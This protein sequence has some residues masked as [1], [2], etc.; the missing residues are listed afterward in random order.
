VAQLGRQLL[1]AQLGQL[2]T[3]EQ[4]RL[5]QSGGPREGVRRC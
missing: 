2:L 5:G 1:I 3:S 4:Q